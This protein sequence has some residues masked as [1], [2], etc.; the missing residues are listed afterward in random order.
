MARENEE[1]P[2]LEN[3]DD[4]QIMGILFDIF[5]RAANGDENVE[6]LSDEFGSRFGLR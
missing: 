1:A 4:G 6:A 3:M 5:G 2:K